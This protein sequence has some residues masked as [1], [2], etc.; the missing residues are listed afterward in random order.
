MACQAFPLILSRNAR[1]WFRRLPPNSVDKF[2]ELSKKFLTEFLAFW[3]QKKLSGYL[4]RL[5]QRNNETLKE[6]MAQFNREKMTA[7]DPT[8][9]KVFATL[10]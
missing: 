5:H 9:D 4:L 1:H 6:F 2:K 8:E 7:E 10:Y 3:T